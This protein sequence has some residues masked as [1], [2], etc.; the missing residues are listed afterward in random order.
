MSVEKT[1][2]T[3]GIIVFLPTDCGELSIPANGKVVIPGNTTY[4]QT[5]RFFCSPGY[6]LQGHK[7]VSCEENGKWSGAA[8]CTIKGW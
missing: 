4:G 3:M 5:A 7:N 8:N 2:L 1:S 6:D